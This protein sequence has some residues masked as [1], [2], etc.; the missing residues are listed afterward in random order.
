MAAGDACRSGSGAGATARVGAVVAVRTGCDTA[1]VCVCRRGGASVAFASTC[2]ELVRRAVVELRG[3]GVCAP[4]GAGLP[5]RL[6]FFSSRGPI[7]SVAG[8]LLV[9]GGVLC[10]TSGAG[11]ST[12]PTVKTAIAKRQPPLIYSRPSS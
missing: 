1:F 9:T 11:P 6:K 8:V 12:S 7:A 2:A 3:G 10:A 4:G 5:S